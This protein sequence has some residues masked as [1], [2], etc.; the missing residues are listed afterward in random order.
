MKGG[1]FEASYT[2]NESITRVEEKKIS[3]WVT[4][5]DKY[6]TRETDESTELY[7]SLVVSD[8]VSILAR[9][10]G[11]MI[12]VVRQFRP[13]VEQYTWELPAGLVELGEDP[14]T[15]AKRELEEEVGVG[16]NNIYSIGTAFVDSGRLCNRIHS[17][18]VDASEPY[19]QHEGEE[20]LIAAFVY[21]DALKRAIIEGHFVNQI[22]IATLYMATLNNFDWDS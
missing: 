8:Y 6:V 14:A 12:P 15:A 20:G 2:S 16:I 4:L 10:P 1:E 7:H 19:T 17:Y 5:A 11:G 18:Y 13:A 22:H 3:Q 9:T 21:P